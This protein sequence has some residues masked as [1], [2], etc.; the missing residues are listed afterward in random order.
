MVTLAVSAR[1]A[2][3]Y[4]SA[5]IADDC[6]DLPVLRSMGRSEPRLHEPEDPFVRLLA[7][8]DLS[9]RLVAQRL[10]YLRRLAPC[11]TNSGV[12]ALLELRIV[13]TDQL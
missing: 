13:Q 2:H 3:N 8:L 6:R 12:E 11:G 1:G 5:N 7:G 10:A 9:S 4:M